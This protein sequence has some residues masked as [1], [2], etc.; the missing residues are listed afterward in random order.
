MKRLLCSALLIL[1]SLSITLS[2][3]SCKGEFDEPFIDVIDFGA[4]YV[5]E[6]TDPLFLGG[7]ENYRFI[8]E[9]YRNGTGIYHIYYST[10]TEISSGTIEFEWRT[11]SDGSVYLFETGRTY[12]DDHQDTIHNHF[13]LIEE[14][15]YYSE[16]FVLYTRHTSVGAR[17]AKFIRE[18]S[19]LKK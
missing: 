12:Y 7:G 9:F 4:R 18:N 3:A 14:P 2:F 11:A 13:F 5:F 1:I 6:S 10:V 17:Y 19:D 16:D 15:I 8:L